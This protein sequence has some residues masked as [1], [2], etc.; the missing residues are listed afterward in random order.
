MSRRSKSMRVASAV[1]AAR[2]TLPDGMSLGPRPWKRRGP[3]AWSGSHDQ[4][5]ERRRRQIERGV[6][7]A[8]EV[9]HA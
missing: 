6:I 7:R 2:A 5:R 1:A 8:T 4:E 9:G 3:R